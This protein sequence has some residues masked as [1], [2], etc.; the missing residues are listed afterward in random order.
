[1]A[2][3]DN[4]E[5][6]QSVDLTEEDNDSC[7]TPSDGDIDDLESLESEIVLPKFTKY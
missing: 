2:K 1:V 5:D 6:V 3:S 4:L 7:S